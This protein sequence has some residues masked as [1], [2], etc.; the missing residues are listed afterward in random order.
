M[1]LNR[2][3]QLLEAL[4]APSPRQ[5]RGFVY[6]ADSERGA[7]SG[8]PPGTVAGSGSDSPPW[9]VVDH[10]PSS[11]IAAKWPGRLMEVE[12]LLRAGQQP[13][14]DAPYTRATKVR[15][16]GE[17]PVGMIFGPNGEDVRALISRA[18]RWTGKDFALLEGAPMEDA[19]AAYSEAWNRWLRDVE[20]G[21]HHIGDDHRHTL[22]AG[23]RG[24]R[25]PVNGAFAVLH[26]VLVSRARELDGQAAFVVEGDEL[27]FAPKWQLALDAMLVAA[28]AL[29]APQGL[30]S[31]EER[32]SMLTAYEQLPLT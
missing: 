26:S 9:I 7:M 22:A 15:V 4:V 12:I 27:W 16:L 13:A 31:A 18:S 3:M 14:A 5:L 19:F 30:L 25:S 10:S 1:F 21:S 24:L 6:V 2:F 29:G 11:V 28:M 20:P 8:A 17:V 23:C 32:E